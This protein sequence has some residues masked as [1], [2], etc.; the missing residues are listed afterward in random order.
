MNDPMLVTLIIILVVY[1]FT[2][3]LLRKKKGH[4]LSKSFIKNVFHNRNKLFIAI[5][6]LLVI[7]FLGV[8]AYASTRFPP[9]YSP[10]LLFTFL[11][12]INFLRGLEEWLYKREEKE[13][14]HSWL[15]VGF[16][17]VFLTVG[18]VYIP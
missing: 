3:L 17:L 9:T 7:A 10:L 14:Q 16:L 11:A 8:A 4:K 12:F 6:I 13:Y 18:F 1:L 15:A 5:D 2:D